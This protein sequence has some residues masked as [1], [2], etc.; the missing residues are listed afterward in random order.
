[1]GRIVTQVEISNPQ[2]EQSFLCS[3]F[4]DTGAGGV[5]LPA[6][7]KGRLGEFRQAE[8]IELVLA[9]RQVV[10]GEVCGPA[11]IHIEGFRK[12]FTEVTFMD[13]EKGDSGE[14]EPLLGYVPL[15]Q[16]Q[17][18]VDMVGHRLVPVKYMDCK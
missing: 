12:I 1:M 7:W 17:V 8:K 2:S 18:A 10:E 5:V 14:Y 4:V 3:M 15:E 6:A 9:N 11:G 13:M 16:T